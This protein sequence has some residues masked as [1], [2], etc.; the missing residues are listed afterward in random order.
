MSSDRMTFSDFN[1]VE[2][3]RCYINQMELRESKIKPNIQQHPNIMQQSKL[4]PQFSFHETIA[5]VL[6]IMLHVDHQS[7][8][9][10][11]TA[12]DVRTWI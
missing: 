1:A 12:V 5:I 3:I 10:R 2:A 9:N 4:K 6:T 8:K 7:N 11:K